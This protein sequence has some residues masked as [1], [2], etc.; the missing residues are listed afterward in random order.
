MIRAFDVFSVEVDFFGEIEKAGAI[1]AFNSV[2]IL[3]TFTAEAERIR[4]NLQRCRWASG[5]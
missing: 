1:E 2:I 4:V 3:L 5:T